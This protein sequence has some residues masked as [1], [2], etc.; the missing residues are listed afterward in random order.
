M[1]EWGETA[2]GTVWDIEG[3]HAAAAGL[4]PCLVDGA[5]INDDDDGILLCSFTKKTFTFDDPSSGLTAISA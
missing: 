1:R 4:G 3:C 2:Q 5:I